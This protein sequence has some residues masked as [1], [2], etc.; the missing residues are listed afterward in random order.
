MPTEIERKFLVADNSWRA[1]VLRR[2]ELRQAYLS[3]SGNVSVRVRIADQ[4]ANLN[5]KSARI[6]TVRQEYEYEIPLEHALELL[7]FASSGV[8]E[9]TRHEVEHAGHLWEIDEFHGDNAGLVVAEIE[10][11]TADEA[12]ARPAWLGREVSGEQRY[13][14]AALARLPFTRW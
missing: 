10:L 5:L 7:E 13:Y 3:N 4:R 14:N 12:F 9:K 8:I 11:D 1:A 2:H 6:G